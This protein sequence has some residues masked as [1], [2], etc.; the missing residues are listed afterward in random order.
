V[1]TEAV[2]NTSKVSSR[3]Y[4]EGRWTYCK[5]ITG[6]SVT[7]WLRVNI[8]LPLCRTYRHMWEWKHHS[9]H[10][11]PWCYMKI[12][13]WLH[14]PAALPRGQIPQYS[15]NIQQSWHHS[16]SRH[17][18][19]DKNLLCLP[20]I[21]SN[22][23]KSQFFN[24]A[25]PT[26][27]TPTALCQLCCCFH[28]NINNPVWTITPKMLTLMEKVYWPEQVSFLPAA[29]FCSNRHF[30]SYNR[31]ACKTCISSCKVSVPAL[32][33]WTK[34]DCVSIVYIMTHH[35]RV[36]QKSVSPLLIWCFHYEE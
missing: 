9:T 35:N 25:V 23:I 26:V 13:G 5:T 21:E 14:T 31:D 20:G 22:Q 24:A 6:G 28:Y 8:Q 27:T 10:S 16:W 33:F 3:L 15:L 32:W 29:S 11:Y 18:G 12:S 4:H 30:V 2:G 7:C 1:K 19:E 17:F 36:P 34:L